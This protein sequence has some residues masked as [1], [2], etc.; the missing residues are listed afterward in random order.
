[1][2]YSMHFGWF[3]IG[4]AEVWIDPEIYYENDAPHYLVRCNINSL[5]WFRFFKLRILILYTTIQCGNM[6]RPCI[7]SYL[8]WK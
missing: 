6:P 4:K 5:P 8:K 1:M 3:K 7:F 2:T